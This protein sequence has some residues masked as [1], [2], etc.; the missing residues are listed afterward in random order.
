MLTKQIIAKMLNKSVIV[1]CI[2]L[3]FLFSQ[4]SLKILSSNETEL[5]LEVNTN[6]Q[7]DE[8]LKSFEILIGLPNSILPKIEIIRSNKKIHSYDISKGSHQIKWV[9]NQKVNG[10]NTAT[11][12]ISPLGKSY[13]Y[14]GKLTIKIPFSFQ[15]TEESNLEKI[16]FDLLRPK[17]INW[18][19]AKNWIGK[20]EKGFL[21]NSSLP[22]GTWIKFAIDNDNIYKIDG[23]SIN[24]LF[25]TTSNFDPRSIMLFSSSAF[26]RDKTYSESQSSTQLKEV[27]VNLLEI[28]IAIFGES[29]GNLSDEDYLF[30][31]ARGP[32]GFNI[33]TDKVKWHQNLYFNKSIYWLLI[34]NDNSL[35]GQRINTA[36]LINDGP[37][38]VDYGVVFNHYEIDNINPQE[39]GLLWGNKMISNGASIVESIEILF[40]ML[41]AKVDGSFGMIGNEKINTRYKN[42]NHSVALYGNDQKIAEFDWENTGSKTAD[43]SID[44][45]I[46]KD[47]LNTF[48]ITNQS[49]NS[50]S[51][52][53]FDYINFSYQ[54]KLIYD[55]PFEFFS[56]VQSTEITF[57]INGENVIIWD[58]SDEMTPVN[59]PVLSAAGETFMRVA[60]PQDSIKRYKVFK[61]DDLNIISEL[62]ITNNKK[63]DNLRSKKNNANHLVIG[64]ESFRNASNQLVNHRTKSIYCSLE[65]IYN[66]F[67]G[68]NEDPIAIKYFLKWAQTNWENSPISVLFM[69]DADFDYRNIT[70]ESKMIVPTLQIGMLNSH[71]TDDRYVA[72]NGVIPE[73]TTG[74][75]P[76]RSVSEV[77]DFGDKIIE[78]ENNMKNG[79]WKQRVTLVADDPVRPEKEKF[80]LSIG[81]SHIHNSEKI[82]GIIPGFMEMKKIYLVKYDDFSEG[83]S[84]NVTKPSATKELIEAIN[85]GTSIINYIGHGNSRQWA[86][87]KLLMIDENRND[88]NLINTEMKLPLWI[89][90]TCNWGHFDKIDEE[91]FAEELIRTPMDGA[92][93]VISTSRGIS[94][95]SNINFLEKIFNQIFKDNGIANLTAGSLLQSVKTGGSDGE[96]F[97]LFGD[98]AMP[99]PLPQTIV[100]NA[101][102][103]PDTL[104]T[105]EIGVLNAQID[106]ASGTGKFILQDPPVEVL[107]DFYFGSQKESVSY[108]ENGSKL[109][110]GDFTY[111][112]NTISPKFRVPKDISFSS[113]FASIRF[114]L[115]GENRFEAIGVASNISFSPGVP[116]ADVDGPIITFL[117]KSGRVLRN[118]D[119]IKIGEEIQ[120]R[121]SDPNGI[122]IT[123]RKG[124]E[125]ILFDKIKSV[126]YYIADRFEYD[127]NSL[128]TGTFIFKPDLSDEEIYINVKA[129]DNAN[130]PNEE[131][132]ILELTKSEIFE[133]RNVYNFPNPFYDK[134]QFSFEI[135]QGADITIDIYT[136]SGLKVNTI[137]SGYFNQGYGIIDW[138]GTDRSGQILSN[139]VYLFQ[140]KASNDSQKTN[141]NGRI[142]IVR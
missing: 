89:A 115:T 117:T 137:Y 128:T 101:F 76:A 46:I 47:G 92:S 25:P 45:G 6:L 82:A 69:G 58:I 33:N 114:N 133:L 64:P 44:A 24:S 57:K 37:F 79:L 23:K 131:K 36:N 26:G 93:A 112:N 113:G 125:M 11:L 35:R 22:E 50:N 31:Y 63:W 111:S 14:F 30:F 68:G 77:S 119:H 66:E 4:S 124:H 81:K 27:P 41:Q 139:G 118:S 102:V 59:Q 97:H 136:L 106:N 140:M 105:L 100:K 107:V 109:F 39:S 29:D 12:Q 110:K 138:D 84:L 129:W 130:N 52:P 38:E 5:I 116:S 48:K 87:E 120:I 98:P 99:L 13:N 67:S 61:T 142:A 49:L 7:S 2:G 90:G 19:I 80:E 8:D 127:I 88:I 17:L 53:F 91:S 123:N 18:D 60:I 70:G 3:S 108:L 28:P 10:L 86:Q 51:E 21:K 94:V 78:F 34:P 95:T 55:K 134:T 71:A 85:N 121:L 135:T 54:R 42:T 9:N 72:F 73:M 141:F 83:S 65:D 104:S 43:F 15:R 1:Y 40:P 56:S 20:L 16:H 32:S 126:E 74:R 122:N 103:T 62:T 75:F 132:I 96:L